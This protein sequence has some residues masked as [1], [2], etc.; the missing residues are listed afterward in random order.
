[1]GNQNSVKKHIEHAERTGVCQLSS[2]GLDEFPAQLLGLSSKL[3]TL[4]LSS[5]KLRGLP[6]AIGNFAV[7]K[8]II[9]N[10]N[11]LSILC[12]GICKLRKLESLSIS[13]N[14]LVSLPPDIGKI[15]SLKVIN[16]QGNKL[17]DIPVGLTQLKHLDS[18]NLSH[19][20]IKRIPDEMKDLQAVE[21][22]LNQNQISSIPECLHQC[23]RLKV[24]RFEENCVPLNAV[25]EK[26]LTESKIS[27][28]AF[29]GNLFDQKTFQD[30]P[31][32]GKYMERYTAT[33]KKFD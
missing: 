30:A 5:N 16:L 18:L 28:L 17:G 7:L 32:Y 9:L 26:L 1:M 27:L 8:S 15:T 31:G 23:P 13:H 3:R 6:E 21:L 19:N 22:N 33:K 24:L 14:R 12:D 20:S 4:D 10:S 25:P 11:S 2:M 29:D